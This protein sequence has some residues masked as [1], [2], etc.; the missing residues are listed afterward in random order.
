MPTLP[1][2]PL[3]PN[4]ADF[5]EE[6]CFGVIIGHGVLERFGL[7]SS[8]SPLASFSAFKRSSLYQLVPGPLLP[9]NATN[10][11]LRNRARSTHQSRSSFFPSA[12][13]SSSSPSFVGI[14][15]VFHGEDGVRFGSVSRLGTVA[16][17]YYVHVRTST[18]AHLDT[19]I[20][21]HPDQST[22]P[23][24]S[25]FHTIFHPQH[26]QKPRRKLKPR[27]ATKINVNFD[28]PINNELDG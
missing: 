11:S 28:E 18:S 24:A 2:P 3:D 22:T 7:R 19:H 16:Y 17:Y 21:A 15:I 1:P 12:S 13:Y 5:A 9:A 23:S 14:V 6:H 26:I 25:I 20:S 8:L 4:V 27:I 10:G